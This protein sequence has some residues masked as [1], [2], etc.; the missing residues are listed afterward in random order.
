MGS[1]REGSAFREK[2]RRERKEEMAVIVSA[3]AVLPPTPPGCTEIRCRKGCG[4]YRR[5]NRSPGELQ[6]T[7]N[8]NGLNYSI[9]RGEGFNRCF[10]RCSS[11]G[12][13]LTGG[14]ATLK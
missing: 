12:T 4:E 3:M 9:I 11:V 13:G 7:C 2:R 6:A 1:E 14:I 10:I 8:D 5:L